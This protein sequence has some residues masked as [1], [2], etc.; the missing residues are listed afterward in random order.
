IRCMCASDSSA[1]PHSP[2][3]RSK[4]HSS[5]HAPSNVTFMSRS[6]SGA[7]AP[8]VA[9][10]AG[11]PPDASA[12]L[13]LQDAHVLQHM[14]DVGPRHNERDRHH[15]ITRYAVA[16]SSMPTALKTMIVMASHLTRGTK[17][18]LVEPRPERP[19]QGHVGLLD[20]VNACPDRLRRARMAPQLAHMRGRPYELFLPRSPLL[21]LPSGETRPLIKSIAGLPRRARSRPNCRRRPHNATAIKCRPRFLSPP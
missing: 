14:D 2:F 6:L 17:P 1:V 13:G 10:A 12:A 9:R 7:A 3:A 11:M 15:G 5:Q 20:L 18:P 8:P 21:P 4:M 19:E 16:L